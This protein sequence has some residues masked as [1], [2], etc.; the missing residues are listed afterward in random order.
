MSLICLVR[1]SFWVGQ[2]DQ[3]WRETGA[4][5]GDQPEDQWETYVAFEGVDL[6]GVGLDLVSEL[7]G[8]LTGLFQGLVVLTHCLVQVGHLD[9]R[10]SRV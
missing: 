2:R 9:G 6:A 1:D 8:L 5:P 7:H 10:R 4:G 3:V